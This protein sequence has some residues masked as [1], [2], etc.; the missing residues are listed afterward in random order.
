MTTKRTRFDRR[1]KILVAPGRE[2]D[3]IDAM[4]VSMR[5]QM[6]NWEAPTIHCRRCGRDLPPADFRYGERAKAAPTCLSCASEWRPRA[7]EGVRAIR[8]AEKPKRPLAP[9]VAYRRAISAQ[10]RWEQDEVEFQAYWVR[11]EKEAA[12]DNGVL[13]P[14]EIEC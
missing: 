1:R 11:M 8:S 9:F 7:S 5:E 3:E 13:D 14:A 4:L 10:I 12:N 6:P 2:P